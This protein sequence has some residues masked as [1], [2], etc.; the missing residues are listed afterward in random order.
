M[1]MDVQGRLGAEHSGVGMRGIRGVIVPM[2]MRRAR[3]VSMEMGV[4][5]KYRGFLA[6][7]RIERIVLRC[8]AVRMRVSVAV[9]VPVVVS[10]VVSVCAVAKIA[11]AVSVTLAM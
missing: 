1:T 6:Q 2:E 8:N 11:V 9:T 3:A 5:G 10:V 4:A 7:R